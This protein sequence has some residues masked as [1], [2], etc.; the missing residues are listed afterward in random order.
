[1]PGGQRLTGGQETQS[2]EFL[3]QDAELVEAIGI[4]PDGNRRP[5]RVQVGEDRVEFGTRCER[6]LQGAAQIVRDRYQTEP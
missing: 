3:L 6:L 1:M 5:L 4:G 2:A